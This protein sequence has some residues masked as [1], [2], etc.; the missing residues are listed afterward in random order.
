MTAVT[1][2]YSG[3][4]D[5][6]A[7]IILGTPTPVQIGSTVEAVTGAF[8][9]SINFVDTKATEITFTNLQGIAGSF[10]PSKMSQLTTL[11][12]PVLTSVGGSFNPNSSAAL[13]SINAPEL[14]SVGGT[15]NPASNAS[16]ATL[17]L[18]KLI[19]VGTGFSCNGNAA[20][21]SI[22]APA[23]TSVGN[24]VNVSS[25]S[26]LTTIS[27]PALTIV[28][29]SFLLSSN[30]LTT[31]SLPSLTDVGQSFGLTFLSSIT[32]ISIPSL[33]VLGSSLTSG[34]VIQLSNGTAALTTFELPS[35]LKQVGS[36]VGNV[37]ITSAALNQTSVDSILVR[38]AAL[39][40]TG[41]TTA[42]SNRTVTI[43]GT[44]A[45]PSATGLDAKATLVA[46]GCTV[47]H[48]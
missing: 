33:V 6:V 15:I 45:T 47:T 48:N 22:S 8:A 5:P 27:F 37:L 20:L 35:T 17:S 1:Y 21:T 11:S 12:L 43:T 30:A 38:L 25:V 44:S 31:L 36:T 13:T 10:S 7:S 2:T 39:D 26:A 9:T 46:R 41:G 32:T 16:L 40:G 14:I 3:P 18:P 24:S 42:F 29:G 34:N 23:L 19:N 28:G 4:A